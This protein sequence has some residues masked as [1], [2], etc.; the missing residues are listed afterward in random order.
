[1]TLGID[2]WQL[3]AGLAAIGTLFTGLGKLLLMSERRHIDE[4]IASLQAESQQWRALEKDFLT[5]KAEL[6]VTYVRREDYTRNQTVIEAK[7][8]AIASELKLV[9]I[10]GAKRG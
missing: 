8:D 9:Q 1:V 5:L 6:P 10:Q 4:Q 3:L 7:L 2:F